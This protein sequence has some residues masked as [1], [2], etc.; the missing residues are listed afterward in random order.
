MPS[1]KS[2]IKL[3]TALASVTGASARPASG[4]GTHYGPGTNNGIE[5]VAYSLSETYDSTNFFDQF[6]FFTGTDPTNGDVDYVAQ[7]VASSGGL[8]EYQNSQ[9]YLGVD[10]TTNNPSGGRESVRLSSNTAFTQ[11]LF[12][13]DIAHMP[14]SICGVWPA[15]W[16]FGPNWPASGEIDIIEGVNAGTTDQVTLHTSS[17]CSVSIDG[18][19]SEATLAN[20]D[21][22]YQNAN[23]GCGVT[24]TDTTNYGNGFN[25]N[26]G[27]VYA[28]QWASDGIYVWFYAH[29]NV[30]SD[31]LSDSPDTTTWGTPM[32]SLRS[33][34]C[35]FG[36]HFANHNIIFDTTFCG[37]WA[38]DVWGSDA[39]CS[40]LAD[41]CNDYVN[42]NPSAFQEAYWLINSVKV[43]Q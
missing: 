8:A 16:T 6:T 14:G 1:T 27:G 28:M 34:T 18:S 31:M 22:N 41:T 5:A 12:I 40:P 20:S 23:T 15:F 9:V 35:D 10:Y 30:P 2:L 36:S 17:G 21:C 39:T 3:A 7:D 24:T 38:G 29:G 11:G 43:F 26:G 33:N 19:S 37:D 4:N 25:S 13:A 32:V 42:G